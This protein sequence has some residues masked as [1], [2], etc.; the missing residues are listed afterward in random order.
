MKRPTRLPA[1]LPGLPD[2]H[3]FPSTKDIPPN[4]VVS[5]FPAIDHKKDL[6]QQAA[7]RKLLGSK[8]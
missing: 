2:H 7:L 4:S 1:G 6:E 5:G 3:I 8:K